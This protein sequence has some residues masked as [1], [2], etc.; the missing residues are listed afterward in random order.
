MLHPFPPEAEELIDPSFDLVPT[1]P[2]R[3]TKD[4]MAV[5]DVAFSGSL[6]DFP[7]PDALEHTSDHRN[8]PSCAAA[9]IELQGTRVNFAKMAFSDAA[10]RWKLLR[11]QSMSLKPRTHEATRNSVNVLARFFGSLRLCDISPG[12]V[13]GYQIARLRNMVRMA[14]E[15]INPWKRTACN[16]T[17]NHEISV[18][19]QMLH[20]CHL[21]H[22]IKPFYF[23]LPVKKWSPRSILTEEQEEQLFAI[24]ALH[25]GASLAY[26]VATI[27]N[28][29]GAA[30]IELRGLRLKHLLF[31]A[32]EGIPEIYVP[33]EAV[34]NIS[35]PRKIALNASAHWAFRQCYVRALKLGS[36]D[37]DHFLFPF[38]I[39]RH[40]YDPT[41]PAG[42][43]FLRKSWAKL[44]TVTRFHQLC[45]HDLRHH[46][47]TKLLES[48]VNIDTAKAILGHV[49]PEMTEYYAHQ[50]KR[51][52]YAAVMAIER[53]GV[54]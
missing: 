30:G 22:H 40:R 45:P 5:P 14:G 21:W 38:C 11:A 12:H 10:E 15:V 1:F 20:H 29:T 47:A 31:L 7:G 39:R 18:L 24:A 36:T 53:K 48:D 37:P 8:C 43:A 26:W 50:R 9:N 16:S 42:S 3:A 34:K 46:F 17:V 28:N 49:R 41:R 4:E 23:P 19:G 33:P 27:T 52:R 25:P 32:A 2:C 35:R 54:A 6:M 44:R 51:V 13:R